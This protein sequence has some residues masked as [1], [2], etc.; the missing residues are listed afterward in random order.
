MDDRNTLG[1]RQDVGKTTGVRSSQRGLANRRA[2]FGSLPYQKIASLLVC[3][4]FLNRL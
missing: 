2:G 1:T 3:C 4:S